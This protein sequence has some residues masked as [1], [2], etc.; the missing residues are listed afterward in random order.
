MQL[1]GGASSFAAPGGEAYKFTK[2]PVT[3]SIEA[4]WKHLKSEMAVLQYSRTTRD[5]IKSR[6]NE[7]KRPE[8]KTSGGRPQE[9]GA[10]SRRDV[11]RVEVDDHPTQ[12]EDTR[13]IDN[14]RETKCYRCG[15]TGHMAADCSKEKDV[16]YNCQK[17]GHVAKDCSKPKRDGQ[18]LRHARDRSRAPSS[19][20]KRRKGSDKDKK[21]TTRAADDRCPFCK[22]L[23]HGWRKCP[24]RTEHC[25]ACFNANKPSKHDHSSCQVALDK[26]NGK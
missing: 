13:E 26:K 8:G 11:R 22:S 1:I 4:V 25:F 12:R 14:I 20:A 5:A 6:L 9:R 15:D 21:V 18:G 3:M 17:P 2:I 16:C 7:D 23:E 24:K 10:S 19:D